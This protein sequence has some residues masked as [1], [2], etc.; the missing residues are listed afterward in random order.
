VVEVLYL[1]WRGQR[2][3]VV[4]YP[5]RRGLWVLVLELAGPDV[6]ARRVI[7]VA[8]A[9]W[10]RIRAAALSKGEEHEGR[11]REAGCAPPPRLGF[12]A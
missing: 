10:E 2:A 6:F 8:S 3:D 4:A 9:E 5:V 12:P 7:R 1:T 11:I